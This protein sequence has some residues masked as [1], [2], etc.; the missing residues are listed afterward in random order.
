[1]RGAFQ[2]GGRRFQ[3]LEGL[4]LRVS[5]YTFPGRGEPDQEC[6]PSPELP[7]V[8]SGA[9]SEELCPERKVIRQEVPHIGAANQLTS[10]QSRF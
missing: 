4:K 9:A 8:V 6:F 10:H 7:G 3:K 5:P 2:L 1:M